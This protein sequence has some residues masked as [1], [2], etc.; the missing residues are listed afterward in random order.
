MKS[1]IGLLFVVERS[2]THLASFTSNFKYHL[3]W[4]K[5][6]IIIII[7]VM[8]IIIIIRIEVLFLS[9]FSILFLLI[10]HKQQ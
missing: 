5:I 1:Y 10:K 2:A 7:I 9:F 6:F 4:I 8:I 3:W